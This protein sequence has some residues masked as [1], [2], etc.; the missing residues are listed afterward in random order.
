MVPSGQKKDHLIKQVLLFM[1]QKD[2]NINHSVISIYGSNF[3]NE[4]KITPVR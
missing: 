2:I 4:R 3:K 1:K